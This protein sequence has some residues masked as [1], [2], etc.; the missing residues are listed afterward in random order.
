LLAAVRDFC[1][2]LLL[3]TSIGAAFLATTSSSQR[4]TTMGQRESTT[5]EPEAA[6][7]EVQ[8]GR[9]KLLADPGQYR[10]SF[11]RFPD[12]QL[13][14]LLPE[15]E[16]LCGEEGSVIALFSDRTAT[17]LFDDGRKF[18]FPFESIQAQLSVAAFIEPGRV[19]L[20]QDFRAYR[21]SFAR[22]EGDALNGWT[23][24]KEERCGAEGQV[25][26]V[27][28]DRTATV[29]FD[30]GASFD[31]PFESIEEQLS[32]EDSKVDAQQVGRV[33]RVRDDTDL[34]TSAPEADVV[35]A[36]CEGKEAQRGR[37]AIVVQ[38]F[39]DRTSTLLFE[40][41]QRLD[42][43][44]EALC[45]RGASDVAGF[46]FHLTESN[47]EGADEVESEFQVGQVVRVRAGRDRAANDPDAFK[48]CFRRFA[49][50]DE[51]NAWSEEKEALRD[52]LAIV[53]QLFS[54]RTATLLFEADR[55]PI[56]SL[57]GPELAVTVGSYISGGFV[58][59]LDFPFE[60]LC[61]RGT[62]GVTG[63]TLQAIDRQ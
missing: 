19:R 44:S 39:S 10:A 54:D 18:D 42:F 38:T 12:D 3:E 32:A 40:D 4:A 37:L 29:A 16:A 31:F 26:R 21:I 20:L 22:F 5:S 2:F 17:I 61:L 41:L 47:D 15:K 1:C 27:F 36:W 49:D 48:A 57:V 25:V 7:V 28:S 8:F 45:L 52:R 50:S 6:T 56:A 23:A 51:L 62:A 35:N 60:A 46:H 43:P 34:R 55:S 13:N 24:E 53:V 58:Q 9:V 33:V 63:F 59:K 14:G 11:V 30:D